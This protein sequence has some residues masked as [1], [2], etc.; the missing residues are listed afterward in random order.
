[1]HI[2]SEST[3]S[4]LKKTKI[5]ST[6]SS[7]EKK[8]YSAVSKTKSDLNG[9]ANQTVIENRQVQKSSKKDDTKN[10]KSKSFLNEKLTKLGVS[11]SKSVKGEK[12]QVLLLKQQTNSKTDKPAIK[13]KNLD[14]EQKDVIAERLKHNEVENNSSQILENKTQQIE[15]TICNNRNEDEANGS[16]TE[17]TEN[18]NEYDVTFEKIESVMQEVESFKL[19]IPKINDSESFFVIEMGLT[20]AIIKLDAIQMPKN[21][22][23]KKKR[24]EGIVL[25][26]E[27]FNQL[28]EHEKEN[29]T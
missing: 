25:I 24:K 4:K 26:H 21:E 14:S 10:T 8:E 3:N 15:T 16:L 17:E 19:D 22:L 9:N 20:N 7:K 28:D 2:E 18:N 27:I 6:K 11:K 1:M 23:L 12:S 5:K 13:S 29:H